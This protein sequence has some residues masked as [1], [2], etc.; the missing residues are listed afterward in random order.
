MPAKRVPAI[1]VDA[2]A[3]EQDVEAT[4]AAP[5]A[6]QP[7]Q[8]RGERRVCAILDA[9]AELITEL[10]AGGLTV[11]ALAERAQTSK[12]SLYHFFPD[13][14]SVLNALSER[15]V[16]AITTLSAAIVADETVDWRLLSIEETV[17][18]FLSP[19]SYLEEHPDLLALA[20]APIV[21]DN[22]TRRLSPIRDVADHIL[23]VRYPWLTA[24]ERLVRASTLVAL[25]DG[26]VGYSLRAPDVQRAAMTVELER[27]TAAYLAAIEGGEERSSRA[28][29]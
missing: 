28:A 10:G 26:I 17:Q 20:R 15:H 7:R 24:P 13:L 21:V 16:A 2:H 23:L 3:P 25:I 12:G 14:Q 1:P 18:R 8:E 5:C 6:R 4:N 19:L 11:Q 27:V 9:A 29:R 22:T